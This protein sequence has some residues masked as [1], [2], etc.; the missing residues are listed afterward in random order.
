M[1]IQSI[2]AYIDRT[3]LPA[4][5]IPGLNIKTDTDRRWYT[6]VDSES[7]LDPWTDPRVTS[8]IDKVSVHAIFTTPPGVERE[9]GTY[10]LRSA[11]GV[12]DFDDGSNSS[13]RLEIVAKTV[14]D[15][16]ELLHKIRTGAIRPT[17]SYEGSQSGR[18]RA[19]L[20][21][22][23][24]QIRKNFQGLLD[25]LSKRWWWP[26]MMKERAMIQMS[27]ALNGTTAHTALGTKTK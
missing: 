9:T 17:E 18:S 10:A 3:Q 11:K 2:R 13:Y 12:L 14:S 8:A 19:E 24:G 23:L 5:G 21:T 6:M 26:F 16:R 22:E 1:S 7:E 20:E 25:R 27:V 15:A 4:D